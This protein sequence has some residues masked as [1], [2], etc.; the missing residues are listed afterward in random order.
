VVLNGAAEQKVIFKTRSLNGA[1]ASHFDELEITNPTVI[2]FEPLHLNHHG[3][4]VRGDLKVTSTATLAGAAITVHGDLRTV[5]GS[6]VTLALVRLGGAL[7]TT[8]VEGDF[9]PNVVQFIGQDQPIKP[10]LA[11][12]NIEITAPVRL[13]GPTLV[14]GY[15][16]LWW[17]NGLSGPLD[18][19]GQTLTVEG[20]FLSTGGSGSLRMVDPADLLI[21]KGQMDLQGG[22]SNGQ[23]SEGAIHVAGNFSAAGGGPVFVPTGTKVVLNGT[24]K[25]TVALTASFTGATRSYFHDL[26]ITNATGV[27]IVRVTSSGSDGRVAVKGSLDLKGMMTVLTGAVLD[28]TETLY[29]RSTSVLA[30]EGTMNVSTCEKENG[31]TISG[32][33]PCP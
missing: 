26:E 4:P 13:V 23:L 19:N 28:I 10:E 11:Y 33:D 31:H 17:D 25:Q 5:P 9:S 8:G 20:D 24:A 30:N 18:F 22:D 14:A 32:T 2:R 27:D 16:K 29:L 6:D 3:A 12:S 15:V 21:V 1:L 7:G